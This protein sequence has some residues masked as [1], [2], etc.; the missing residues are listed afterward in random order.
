M[1]KFLIRYLLP[2]I[3]IGVMIDAVTDIARRT[4]LAPT[5][6][7]PVIAQVATLDD[8]NAYLPAAAGARPRGW[9]GHPA[10]AGRSYTDAHR[11]YRCSGEGWCMPKD[12]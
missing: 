3:C 12:W 6:P 1:G 5:G 9:Q 11:D 8:A 10:M 4:V 7:A 2:L